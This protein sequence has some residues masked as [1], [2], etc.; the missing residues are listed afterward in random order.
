MK[1]S[2]LVA[3]PLAFVLAA[4]G[5]EQKPA[6]SLPQPTSMVAPAPTAAPV[7]PTASDAKPVAGAVAAIASPKP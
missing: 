6:A 1:K 3:A 2:L 5:P 7:P 4:C